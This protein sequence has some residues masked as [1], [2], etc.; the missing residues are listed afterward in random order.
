MVSDDGFLM[1]GGIVRQFHGGQG[2]DG[3][4]LAGGR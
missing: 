1:M 4:D 2:L 3:V